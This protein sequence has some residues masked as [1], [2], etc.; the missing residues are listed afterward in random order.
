MVKAWGGGGGGG[1]DR[2]ARA[3]VAS[4]GVWGLVGL[5]SDAIWEVK[6][7]ILFSALILQLDYIRS[8]TLLLI[9]LLTKALPRCY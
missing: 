4:R 5:D 9:H 1:G 6:I 2:I 7:A 3:S 8:C